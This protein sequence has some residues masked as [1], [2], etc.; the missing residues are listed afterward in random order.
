MSRNHETITTRRLDDD[1][2]LQ[3]VA[4]DPEVVATAAATT[5]AVVVV[6]P[7][8]Y[9]YRTLDKN[10]AAVVDTFNE[11]ADAKYPHGV[12]MVWKLAQRAVA[13]CDFRRNEID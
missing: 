6:A 13:E 4:A 11:L 8:P 10:T 2:N 5:A 12:W 7:I 3:M 9:V 1:N